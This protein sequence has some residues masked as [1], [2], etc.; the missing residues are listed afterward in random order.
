M[1]RPVLISSTIG[2]AAAA[3]G[4]FGY[5]A[6]AAGMFLVASAVCVRA[7]LQPN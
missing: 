7:A 6:I 1:N 5:N 4:V 2:L 3:F